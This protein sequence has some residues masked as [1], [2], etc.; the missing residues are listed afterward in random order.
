MIKISYRVVNRTLRA[1]IKVPKLPASIFNSEL[2]VDKLKFDVKKQICGDPKVQKYMESTADSLRKMYESGMTSKTLWDA[3]IASQAKQDSYYTVKDAFEYY[4]RTSVGAKSTVRNIESVLSKVKKYGLIDTPIN[5]ITGAT[6]R[7]FM[8][9]LSDYKESSQYEVYMK[10]KTVLNRY[11]RE[12]SLGF[13]LPIDGLYKVPKKIEA[14]EPEYLTWS[15]VLKLLELEMAD[16]KDAYFRDLFCLMCLTGMAVGDLLQFNP[17]KSVSADKKWFRYYRKKNSNECTSIPLLPP[18]LQIIERNIWPVMISVRTLQYKCDI[19]SEL[20]GRTI[21][22]H[23]ARKTFGCVFLELGFSISS[24]SKMMGHSSI[25]ITEKY[26]VRISQ[27]K[28]EREMSN[29]PE[30][31]KQMMNV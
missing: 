20:I 9:N 10:L 5:Q 24:I 26:Y 29:L 28:I 27:A 1:R 19:I 4:L 3:F 14:T 15:E 6:M 17:K 18:A 13:K 2:F 8:K 30:S 7:E 12:N 23:G 22:T 21:K 31:V 11:V 25:T 16:P